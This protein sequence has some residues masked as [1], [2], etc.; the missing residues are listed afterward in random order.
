MVSG[1]YSST[2][3]S[4]EPTMCQGPSPEILH[5]FNTALRGQNVGC[6]RKRRANAILRSNCDAT[7]ENF[8]ES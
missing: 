2:V 4:H 7:A 3:R 6:L 8:I 5:V 1:K